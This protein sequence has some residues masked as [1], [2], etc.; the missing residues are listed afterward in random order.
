MAG[1]KKLINGILTALLEKKIIDS[2]N[3]IRQHND[4]PKIYQYAILL[5]QPK[6]HLNGS[7]PGDKI[8]TSGVSFTSREAALLKCVGEAMERFCLYNFSFKNLKRKSY[9]DKDCIDISF[10]MRGRV[11]VDK[12]L[13]WTAGFNLT[14]N[15]KVFIPAQITYLSF[16]R[17]K[18][19]IMLRFPCISTGA[20][21]SF[22]KTQALING[23]YEVVERDSFMNVYLGKIPVKKIDLRVIKSK[24]LEN[25]LKSVHKCNMELHV[26][27]TTNDL[28]IPSFLSLLV[29]RTGIGP[30]VTV[31][32]KSNLNVV[33]AIIG[34]IAE[35][36]MLRPWARSLI[37]KSRKEMND[38]I[39]SDIM[40]KRTFYWL[41]PKMLKNL[42]FLLKKKEERYIA[43]TFKKTQAE[44]LTMLVKTIKAKGYEIFYSDITSPQIKKF[45]YLVYKV[46]IPSLQ[47]L[48]LR[49]EEKSFVNI[50]RLKKVAGYFGVKKAI[51]NPVP[52]PFL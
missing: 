50:K 45:G 26:F 34:S 33:D 24:I 7:G 51:I 52:H 40:I 25:I 39:R 9:S 11:L 3:I 28:S 31:G 2:V 23:I 47:P 6:R 21:G 29:D 12:K 8:S 5:N 38:L 44:E 27:N 43:R 13:W 37:V 14:A 19:E 35:S 20:A 42:A 10:L 16:P 22:N 17:K 1:R 4:D 48:Y 49:E 15:K 18:D 30:A 32:S 46:F 41:D 36:I